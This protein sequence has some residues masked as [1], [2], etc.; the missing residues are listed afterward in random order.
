VTLEDVL[1]E[2]VGDII[3][4]SDRP[5]EEITELADGSLQVLGAIEMRKLCSRLGVAWGHDQEVNTLGGLLT[6]LLDRVPREGDAV[7]WERFQ[8]EVLEASEVRA[9]V[10][11]VSEATDGSADETPRE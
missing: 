7:T 5:I 10:I 3:D 6:T 9:E 4:E 2:L 8:L 11:R 1:E